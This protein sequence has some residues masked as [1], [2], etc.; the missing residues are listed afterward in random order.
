MEKEVLSRRRDKKLTRVRML[1]CEEKG[2]L[3]AR[4][5]GTS[6]T[7]GASRDAKGFFVLVTRG[8]DG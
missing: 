1:A 5:R 7:W 2:G 4:D 6:D 3:L 8:I